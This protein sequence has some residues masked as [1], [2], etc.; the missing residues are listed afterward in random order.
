MNLSGWGRYPI[1]DAQVKN[2][3]SE[4]EIFDFLAKGNAIARGNGRSYG[5]SSLSESN[6]ISMKYFDRILSFNRE[7][8]QLVVEAG[9]IL[10]DLIETF[11]PSGW[12]PY[13]TPGTKY[14]TV[15][16]MIAA[17][18]H[19]KNHHK[20]GSFG[21]YV[22]WID[23][24]VASGEVKR[25]SRTENS[26][27]FEWTIGGMGLTG[28]I[29]R[30]AIRFRPIKSAWIVQKTIAAQNIKQAIE[31]FEKSKDYTYSVAWIDCLKKGSGLGRS[32]V[33]LGEH[34]STEELPP[35][36]V[37]RPLFSPLKR[38]VSVP[39]E[40]P[41][42]VLNKFS[43]RFFNAIYFW[44]RKHQSKNQI[45]D[46]DSYF[47]PLDKL[48]NWNKIYGTKGFAQY[49]SVVPLTQ[50]ESGLC[51]LLETISNSGSGSFLS[52][53]KRFGPQDSRFSFPM[54]GYTLA[55]D[56]PISNRNLNLMTELDKITMK[57]GGRFYLAKDARLS[58]QDFL[59]S[60]KR[61]IDFIKYRKSGVAADVYNSAQS[62][63]LGL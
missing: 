32:L 10:S 15:G 7:T 34:A 3:R 55:L 21:R 2:P 37:K 42:W 56:F 52:V 12:F 28:I 60:E 22:E 5:D 13:V 31:I 44:Y 50:A 62:E 17:D 24:V 38:K 18:V 63:R 48:I 46:W 19:G 11:L 23:I 36:F 8:G 25:C 47:Y 49:Q 54:E 16:G 27:L 43:V 51:E 4:Q 1:L 9:V 35:N 39:F 45:V 20:D 41:N 14:V 30:A 6:T 57:H 26:E 40:F 61:A 59:K 58:K 33:M 53:L 29:L